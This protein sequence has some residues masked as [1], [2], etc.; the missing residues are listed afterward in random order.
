[1]QLRERDK[2]ILTP[3]ETKRFIKREQEVN[4]KRKE[5]AEQKKEQFE[6]IKVKNNT[7]NN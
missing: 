2:P 1:M 5:Y 7:T 6:K 4:E 3:D